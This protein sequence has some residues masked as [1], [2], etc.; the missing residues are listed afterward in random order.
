MSTAVKIVSEKFIRP[1]KT[2]LRKI[3]T[4][5][6]SLVFLPRGC[7]PSCIEVMQTVRAVGIG[8]F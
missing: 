6:V 4:P 3:K 7:I 8:A 5:N 1:D 2:P